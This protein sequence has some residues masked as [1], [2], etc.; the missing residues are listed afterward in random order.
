MIKDLIK[1]KYF[2]MNIKKTETCWLWT[3][4]LQQNGYGRCSFKIFPTNLAHRASYSLF[5]G[6]ITKGLHVLHK[7]DIKNCVNPEHLFLGTHNDNM[8]DMVIKQRSSFGSKNTNAKLND[9]IVKE[10]LNKY[11]TEKISK[12]ALAK[13]YGIGKSQMGA[14][15]LRKLWKHIK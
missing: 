15:I 5:R 3:G 9:N 2:Y 11:S 14:I 7:C 1:Y 4:S 10:I 12:V 13:E 8:K 6:R